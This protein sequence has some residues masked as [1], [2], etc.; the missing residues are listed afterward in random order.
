M[1]KSVSKKV[2]NVLLLFGLALLVAVFN[3]FLIKAWLFGDGPANLSSIEVSYVSMAN[4]LVRDFPQLSWAPFWYFGFPFYL[5]YTPVLPVLV[6]VLKVFSGVS[7]WQAYRVISGAGFVLGPVSLFFLVFYLTKDRLA[8][9]TSGFIYSIM[10][11]IFNF[12]LSS[13]EVRRDSFTSEF[14]DPRRLVNL[15]R[16]GEG[17]HTFSLVF[18]PLAVLFYFKALKD[19]KASSILLAAGF[20]AATALTNAIGLYALAAFLILI[21]LVEIF[22][23]AK[24]RTETLLVSFLVGLFAYGIS[25][26]W[27]N[28]A[29]IGTF[30]G[31]GEGILKVWVSLFP[32]GW[33]FL[34]IGVFGVLSLLKKFVKDAA[35]ASVLLWT[36][37][38]FAI[39]GTYYFSAPPEFFKERIELAP[40]ALRYMTEIDMGMAA[41]VGLAIGAIAKRLSKKNKVLGG[42]FSLLSGGVIIGAC[43]FYGALYGPAIQ[44]S[45]GANVD[46]SKTHEKKLASFLAENIDSTKGERVYITGNPAFFLNFFTDVWQLRGG[47]YQAMAHPW[48]SHIY[49]QLGAGK[50]PEIAKAWLKVAN[51]KYA[52][53]VP[54]PE[55]EQKDKFKIFSLAAVIDG[56]MIYKVTLTNTSPV[57]I[58]N[59]GAMQVLFTPAKGD[60]KG[61]ILAYL[62]W[63]E[64]IKEQEASFEKVNNN[65]YKIKAQVG[66][67]EGI[68][69]QMTAD[70][71]WKA[72]SPQGKIGIAKDPLGF[73]V[74]VP[75]APGEYE[76]TLSHHRTGVVWLGYLMTVLTLGAAVLFLR[77]G[78]TETWLSIKK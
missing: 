45:L 44:G 63:L 78:K 18:L 4:F 71:G 33:V 14:V 56:S 22:F 52:V 39:V 55:V 8:A 23:K 75:A 59:L 15:A 11:T 50:D 73:L 36:L 6:A 69:V 49:Y 7:F 27:Y 72:I 28:F 26:F 24:K 2:F 17:P 25:A 64:K 30:F 46:L 57:K 48:P 40:Q 77:V 1:F 42:V 76:I 5:F 20:T 53:I 60:D 21:F 51:T 13:G 70:K 34:V 74:L 41:L 9:L 61:P 10:P 16:W 29:F 3:I 65:L 19:R 12:I 68:L 66:Q 47:L 31:E 67:G 37:A 58:V 54:G 38:L 35:C 32:W 62:G 43:V